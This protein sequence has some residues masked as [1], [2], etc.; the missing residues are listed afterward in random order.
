MALYGG[1]VEVSY[2]DPARL[3]KALFSFYVS[4]LI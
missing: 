4:D 2:S 1:V 3:R